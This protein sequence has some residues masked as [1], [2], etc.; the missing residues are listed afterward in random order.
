[1]LSSLKLTI[2]TYVSDNSSMIYIIGTKIDI[3]F[4]AFFATES[5]IK[6]ICLGF[7]MEK[8]SYLRDEWS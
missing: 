1:M 6:M 3:V 8:G 7:I 2:D 5:L 4:T